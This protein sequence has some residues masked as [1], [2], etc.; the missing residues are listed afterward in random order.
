MQQTDYDIGII[1]GGLAGLSL[2]I[3]AADADYKVALFEKEE[4]PFHKV[5]GEYISLE[6]YDFL[7]Q[8]SLPLQQMN[9]PIIKHL[10]VSDVKGKVYNF[11][12]DLGGFGISRYKIDNAL[13]E[14]A[15]QKGVDVF[16]NEKVNEVKFENDIQIIETNKKHTSAQVIAAAY[17]KRSNLDIKWKRRFAE[18]KA[19]KLSNHIGVKYHIKTNYSRDRIA[20]HNFK[21]GYCGI[22]AIED[23]KYCLCYLTNAENLFANNNSIQQMQENVLYKNPVLKKIFTKSEFLYNAPLTISQISFEPKTLIEN[24]ALML[25]DAAGMI[26]PLCGNGMSMAM[27]S[28]KLAIHEIEEF[29]QQK[30]S[31]DEMERNYIL[32]W[33]QKFA[34]RLATGRIIQEFMGSNISTTLFLKLMNGI[35]ALSKKIIT[36]THGKP[37]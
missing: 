2:A 3:L 34:M 32:N 24:H 8:L 33:K 9:L 23:D 25:G 22:S 36:S 18:K 37:F 7:Q 4:Y 30:I 28:A 21:N 31:R 20:L 12:L 16:T 29:L 10:Q 11:K 17:G 27:H 15:K 35:P 5:C 19:G 26:T 13:Y 6:S 14:H 1:G